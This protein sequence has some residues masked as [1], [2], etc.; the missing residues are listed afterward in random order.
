[1]WHELA[2]LKQR[3]RGMARRGKTRRDLVSA[4]AAG[5]AG[6][7]FD[8][9]VAGKAGPNIYEESEVQPERPVSGGG[10]KDRQEDEEVESVSRDDRDK[11]FREIGSHLELDT[12]MG[13]EV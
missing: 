1:M 9:A 6:N 10:R 11:G 5:E 7:D 12:A 8:D 2:R 3:Y 4:T 13:W